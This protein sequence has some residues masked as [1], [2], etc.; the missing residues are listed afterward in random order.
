MMNL[1]LLLWGSIQPGG[2]STWKTM[3]IS[4]ATKTLNNHVRSDRTTFHVVNYNQ[5]TGAVI[6]KYTVQGYSNSSTRA[7]QMEDGLSSQGSVH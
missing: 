6:S 1:E 2:S 5:K 7:V 3:A 4:H